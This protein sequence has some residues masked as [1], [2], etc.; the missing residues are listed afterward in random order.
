[1]TGIT[2]VTKVASYFVPTE[3][4]L[5]KIYL[6]QERF[7]K[8]A[9]ADCQVLESLKSKKPGINIALAAPMRRAAERIYEISGLKASTI[10]ILLEYTNIFGV[11]LKSKKIM[12]WRW[13]E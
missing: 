13:Y 10:H 6:E 4:S 3:L 8:Y 5:Q 12:F 11:D 1:M 2:D 9:P 7:K